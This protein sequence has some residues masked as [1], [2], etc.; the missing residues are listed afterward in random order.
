MSLIGPGS[1]IGILGAGQLGRMLAVKARQMGYFVAVYGGDSMSPC[2]QVSDHC[3][4][5]PLDNIEQLRKFAK[6]CD[7]VTYEFENIPAATAEIVSSCTKLCPG[8]NLLMTAQNRFSEKTTFQ[9]LGLATPRFRMVNSGEQLASA[10][11]DFGGDVIL[12]ANTEGY[13]GRGQWRIDAAADCHAI[14]PQTGLTEAIVEERIDFE[15]EL[16]IVAGRYQHGRCDFFPP[17]LND[18]SNHIL[19]LTVV[20]S[21]KISDTIAAQARETARVILDHFDITGVLCLELFLTQDQRLLVNEIAPRPH[22]SGHLTIEAAN[23]SQFELQLR[24]ICDLP[25]VDLKV[26][27]A[28]MVNLLGKHLPETW[29]AANLIEIGHPDTQLHLYGKTGAA[30][31]RK[32]GHLTV[33]SQPIPPSN[34]IT[35]SSE[36]EEAARI[37]SAARIQLLK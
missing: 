36:P 9:K 21:N 37:A 32:M 25:P 4:D 17:F 26:Q 6:L 22:N 24:T 28:A 2:G 14:W 23:C 31:N 16:S 5:A 19:D 35:A 20:H 15:F 3:F 33:L 8:S 1:T 18:H 7:V 13:D 30:P 11:A 34:T 27:P 10:R 12:K 29:S